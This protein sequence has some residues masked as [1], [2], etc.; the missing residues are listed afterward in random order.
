MKP[1][2]AFPVPV[3]LAAQL[4]NSAVL[5]QA[6]VGS[7]G[8]PDGGKSG[9]QPT[10]TPVAPPPSTVPQRCL[11]TRG[12]FGPLSRVGEPP[13]PRR[14]PFFADGGGWFTLTHGLR[15]RKSSGLSVGEL[16]KPIFFSLKTWI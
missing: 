2:L 6:P 5:G 13:D 7:P 11:C 8:K 10:H 16:E 9:P 1:G 14:S 3:P 4:R 12:E 15:R